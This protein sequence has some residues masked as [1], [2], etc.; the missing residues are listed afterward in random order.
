[1]RCKMFVFKYGRTNEEETTLKIQIAFELKRGVDSEVK[2]V[3]DQRENWSVDVERRE[4]SL[5][6]STQ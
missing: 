3:Q 4:D 5:K 2:D 1:M 6:D